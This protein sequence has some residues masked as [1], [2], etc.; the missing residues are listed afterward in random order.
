MSSNDN[1]NKEAEPIAS[2]SEDGSNFPRLKRRR[3]SY[4]PLSKLSKIF[5]EV[6]A[7]VLCKLAEL[8]A[9]K[10]ISVFKLI[11]AAT[12][13]QLCAFDD[14]VEKT[15]PAE[16]SVAGELRA[17]SVD[18]MGKQKGSRYWEENEK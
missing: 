12:T 3:R 14:L 11:P 10:P 5:P 6:E 16:S 8:T 18:V 2:D 17:S 1:V 15:F 9:C 13:K 4:L 7:E